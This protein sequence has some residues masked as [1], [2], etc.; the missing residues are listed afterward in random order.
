MVSIESLV[1]HL[2]TYHPVSER[3]EQ[4]IKDCLVWVVMGKD[5][6]MVRAWW[7]IRRFCSAREEGKSGH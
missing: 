2:I 3:Y 7:L 4:V 6:D 5:D 1:Q